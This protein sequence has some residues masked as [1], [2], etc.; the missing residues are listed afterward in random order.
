MN[1]ISPD[2]SRDELYLNN[3]ALL[4]IK[5]TLA[6]IHG[7]GSIAIFGSEY[8]MRIWLDPNKLAA[9]N[10]TANDVVQAIQEQNKQVAAGV[11]GQQPAPTGTQFQLVVNAAG[12]IG[13]PGG[14]LSHH[15]QAR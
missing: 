5:D 12:T 4:Q 9:L 2:D 11:V 10:L 6:R 15:H 8:S 1:L 13:G 7:V 3:Y 14:I